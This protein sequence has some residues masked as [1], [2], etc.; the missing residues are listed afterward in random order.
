MDALVWLG[1]AL[2]IVWGLL[3]IIIGHVGFLI[4]I[5]L[6]AGIILVV[7]WTFLKRF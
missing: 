7:G 5:I 3:T 4:N 1:M 6:L 2:V